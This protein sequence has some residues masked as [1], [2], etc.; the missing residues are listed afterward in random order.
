MGM[1][2]EIRCKFPLP[3]PEYQDRLFQT[4]DTPAQWLDMYEI[5]EDGALW[6]EEYDMEDHSKAGVWKRENPGKKVPEELD[7]PNSLFCGCLTRVNK[8]WVKAP[9]CFSGEISFYTTLGKHHSGWVEFSAC[10]VDGRVKEIKLIGHRPE[11]PALDEQRDRELR[12]RFP[13]VGHNI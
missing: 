5:R 8:R 7:D 13:T 1:F 11:D 10:F 9:Y 4:K 6:H 2:D 12:K 3:L